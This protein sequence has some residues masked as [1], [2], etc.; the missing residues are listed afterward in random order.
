[1]LAVGILGAPA[2]ASGTHVL[3]GTIAL[4]VDREWPVGQSTC[5]GPAGPYSDVKPGADVRV[6]DANGHLLSVGKL[7]AGKVDRNKGDTTFGACVFRF[8]VANVPERNTYQVVVNLH[9]AAIYSAEDQ[10]YAEDT[11]SLADMKRTRW[12]RRLAIGFVPQGDRLAP[13]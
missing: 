10:T 13:P 7:G 1:M 2:A 11:T 9:Q 5:A 12:T 8:R 3:G 4:N 6:A